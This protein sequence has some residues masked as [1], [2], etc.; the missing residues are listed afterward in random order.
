MTDRELLIV[1][2]AAGKG[3]RMRSKL[4][5]VLHQIAGRSMLGHVLQ[6][7][8]SYKQ[9]RVSVV[10]G[11]DMSV[12]ATEAG[13]W[14]SNVS[15]F[16][17]EEAKGTAHAVL[18]AEAA[19]ADHVGDV[20]VLYADTPLVTRGTLDRL[21]D[22][23]EAGDGV[24]VLG[25]EADD[26]TGYGRLICDDSGGLTAIREQKDASVKERAVR[27]CNSGL[28]AFRMDGLHNV[29]KS[30]GNNNANGEY[31]LTDMVEMA[32]QCGLQA[33]VA[34]CDEDEVMGVNT[35]GQLAA[36][37]A[38]WQQ[39]ARTE[40][41]ASGVTMIDPRTVTLAYDTQLGRDV[42]LEPS[43]F[44]GPG[45]RVGDD[46]TIK[47]NCHLEG[48]DAKSSAGVQVGS[49]SIIGP[50]ARLRPGAHL[51]EGVH[52][53]NFVEIKNATMAQSAK[54]NHLTY[55][56][57]AEIGAGSNIGAGTIFCNYDGF[58][59][60]KSKLGKGVFVGS[61]S[62][63]VAPVEIGHGAYVGAGSTITRDVAS[64]SL[65]LERAPQTEK[66]GWAETFRETHKTPTSGK[67]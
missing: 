55:I 2:L 29:L 60:A 36:A 65:A 62:A 52:I 39:R 12:V 61:N 24:A 35:R 7:A 19:L 40:A 48:I 56:G 45:V 8:A 13:R 11:P 10:V 15:V 18:A 25:F 26:P 37:E 32:R 21:L 6:L 44:F 5:K 67:T 64:N 16:V 53:G 14:A 57:D 20:V 63:L 31:Y 27:L 9:A 46:V 30:I 54:A 58:E 51:G 22:R 43:V 47:A 33:G 34:V 1:V 41:M 49:G 28:M 59:K 17:Q 66:E 23:L 42:V 3:T 4:P 50:F 38:L